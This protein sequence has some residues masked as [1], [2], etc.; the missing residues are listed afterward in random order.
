MI[1]Y[2]RPAS[3]AS[4]VVAAA[5]LAGAVSASAQSAGVISH[6]LE[7]TD[8]R[9]GFSEAD[10]MGPFR[11]RTPVV[12]QR[13]LDLLKP[14]GAASGAPA[15]S[16]PNGGAESLDVAPMAYGTAGIPYTT[17]RAAVTRPGYAR[18][19]KMVPITSRPYS[20]TGKLYMKFGGSTFVCT[21]S[22]LR[23]GILVTAAHCISE[24]GNGPAGFADAAV[25]YPA[26]VSGGKRGRPFG[27]F[28]A[29]NIFV[30]EPYYDGSDTCDPLY[31]GIVCNND[32]AT[33]ALRKEKVRFRN[34]RGKKK[35]VTKYPGQLVGTYRFGV[36]GY[37]YTTL[38]AEFGSASAAQIT[39][40]GYPVALDKGLQMQRTDSIGF[41]VVDGDLI[42]TLI[43]SAQ[44]GGS[45]GGPWL[46]NFGT[47]PAVDATDASLGFA[48]TPNVVVGV[49]SYGVETPTNVNYQGASFFGQNVEYPDADYGGWGPGNI[50]ALMMATCTQNAASC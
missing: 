8:A 24:F 18:N 9:E 27:R 34:F 17:V 21:A 36:N 35:V 49:T 30:P 28:R 39:Q 47:R 11:T 45:S 38:P 44:T 3:L 19:K 13:V 33:I 6:P 26:M 15:V 7:S 31:P 40:L 20:T 46:V 48:S 37:S 2:L 1:R 12:D 22:L 23:K 10:L 29:V 43:G 16:G 14:A 50:G 42:N 25:W 41:R 5:C 4:T 32:V